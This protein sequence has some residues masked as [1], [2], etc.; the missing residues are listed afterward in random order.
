MF[1]VEPNQ[2][3]CATQGNYKIIDT[4]YFIN[5]TLDLNTLWN[6]TITEE[7]FTFA[8]KGLWQSEEQPY[9][10]AQEIAIDTAL[11]PM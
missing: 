7:G 3:I 6:T 11:S 8:I 10:P 9:I 5:M 4:S 2:V 1:A